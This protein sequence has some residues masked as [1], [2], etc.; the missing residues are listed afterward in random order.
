MSHADVLQVLRVLLQRRMQNCC[1]RG[2][3]AGGELGPGRGTALNTV[4][5]EA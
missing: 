1:R 3:L 4:A 2:D 5:G